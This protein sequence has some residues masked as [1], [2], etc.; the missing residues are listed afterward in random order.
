MTP[1]TNETRNLLLALVLSTAVLIGWYVYVGEQPKPQPAATEETVAAT[2]APDTVHDALPVTAEPQELASGIAADGMS[3]TLSKPRT[4]IIQDSPRVRIASDALH[5]S[6]SL[7]GARFDDLT[8]AEYRED[9]DKNSADVTLLS[10]TGDNHTYFGQFGW[11]ASKGVVVPDASTIWQTDSTTLTPEKPIQLFWDSPQGV[12]FELDISLDDHF[13]FTITQRIVNR[14][15]GTISVAPYGLINRAYKQQG[16]QFLILH[17]GPLGV[18][19]DTLMEVDYDDLKEEGTQTFTNSSGWF[20]IT[21]KYWLTAI[22]PGEESRFKTN[23]QYY[24]NQGQDRYQ[25]DMLGKSITIPS[26]T[27]QENTVRFFAGAKEVSLLDSYADVHHIPLF[28]RAVDFGVLYFLTKPIF[29]LLSYFHKLVGNFGVA[30][31]LLTVV[32]KL[33]MFPLANKSYKSMGQMKNLMPKMQ[34]IR[35]RY[36][37]DRI[38]MNQEIMELYKKEGVNPA[39]GCLPMLLQIPVFFAL[40]KVLFV[41]IEMRHA[42]FFGWIQDLSAKDPTNFFT[43]FGLLPWDAPAF[44]HI[45][46]WPLIMSATMVIQQKLNPKPT[47]PVQAQVIALMPYAFLFLFANFP[48]GLVIY[49]AWNNALSIIQ[50][51]FITRNLGDGNKKTRQTQSG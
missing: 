8:L 16:E 24:E 35:D 9:V 49:W 33:V 47:D 22:I 37:D 51:W 7:K 2:D 17:T 38:K 39:S 15:T 40:Y 25:V 23:Y 14:A 5:G 43:M 45:G 34:E 3:A 12:R 46:I 28:D 36:E 19:D 48:A 1:E 32:I 42:P 29:L 11:L 27:A 26:G 21:D 18:V 6:I 50:Q 30:I 10:P 31:L 41:T 44:L 13:M 4:E 20:G